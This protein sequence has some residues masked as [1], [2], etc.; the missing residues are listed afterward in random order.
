MLDILIRAPHHGLIETKVIMLPCGLQV[1]L[2]SFGQTVK[3]GCGDIYLGDSQGNVFFKGIV[4]AVKHDG[5]KAQI[6]GFF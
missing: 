4:G 1:F 5:C 3:A 6:Q 2:R